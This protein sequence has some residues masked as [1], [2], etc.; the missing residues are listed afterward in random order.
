[1]RSLKEI[2]D[3]I[4]IIEHQ[5]NLDEENHFFLLL[6]SAYSKSYQATKRKRRNSY[7]Y[8]GEHFV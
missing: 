1:M 3:E 8:Q 7:V 2:D 4:K 5:K 6:P